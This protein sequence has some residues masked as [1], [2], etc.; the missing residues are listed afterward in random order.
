VLPVWAPRSW[1]PDRSGAKRDF[2]Q[3]GQTF[4]VIEADLLSTIE[5][6]LQRAQATGEMDRVNA[7]FA[8]RVEAKVRRPV[9]VAGISLP[10]SSRA[11]EYRPSSAR[12]KW[13]PKPGKP[14]KFRPSF[15]YGK[16]RVVR[17]VKQVRGA[18]L[19]GPVLACLIRVPA[20]TRQS[21]LSRTGSV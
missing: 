8:K 7:A 10:R 3:L 11:G 1:S 15:P 21:G 13:I 9:P 18:D 17:R 2:G 14:G 6:R 19:R 4:P 16:D 20:R 5:A 12:R